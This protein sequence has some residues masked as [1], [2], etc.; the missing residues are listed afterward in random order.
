ME[1]VLNLGLAWI[2]VILVLLTAIIYI[3]RIV[4]RRSERLKPALQRLNRFLRKH[5]KLLGLLLII[6]GLIHGLF[7]SDTVWSLNLGTVCWVLSVLLG[8]N[9]LLK[10]HFRKSKSWMFYHRWLTIVFLASLALHLFDTGIQAPQ[11]LMETINPTEPASLS[12][13]NSERNTENRPFEGAT[14]L[15]GTYEG[16]ATGYRPGLL[17]E[18]VVKNGAIADITVTEHHEVNSRYYVRPMQEIPATIIENQ[19]LDVDIIAG[20][21]RT[22][23]GVINAVNDAVSKAVTS[24]VIAP[25]ETMPSTSGH[26]GG[27]GKGGGKNRR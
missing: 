14:L 20:A 12:I 15:D 23:V 4:A 2:A 10:K 22:S 9:W 25:T 17:V 7:S 13:I 1:L 8:L 3:L 18:V 5:H 16:E 11:I 27:G 21:T 19:S 6:A 24:G 26:S